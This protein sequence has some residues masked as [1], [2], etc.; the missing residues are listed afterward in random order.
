HDVVGGSNG[1]PVKILMIGHDGQLNDPTDKNGDDFE[2][3][4]KY[5]PYDPNVG[6]Q[7]AMIGGKG[8]NKLVGGQ[9]EFGGGG[10]PDV[11][12]RIKAQDYSDFPTW[13]R[14]LSVHQLYIQVQGS[15][16]FL[17]ADQT[18]NPLA[19]VPIMV[20]G[21]GSDVLVGTP[22]ADVLYGGSTSNAFVG[23]GGGD[24]IRG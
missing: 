3:F 10:P 9:L 7:I 20:R 13:A 21:D 23:L 16:E 15:N 24:T 12:G 11:A 1:K 22:G 18:V 5:T 2:Y 8:N 4:G 14:N 19:S 17:P 6:L